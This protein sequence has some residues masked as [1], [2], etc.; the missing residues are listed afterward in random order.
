MENNNTYNEFDD[1]VGPWIGKT[2]KMLSLFLRDAFA[3]QG[4]DI[5]TQQFILLKVLHEAD[6]V[7][8]GDLAFITDRNKGSLTRLIS[9]LEKKNYVA[10][11]PSEDDKRINKIFLTRSGRDAYEKLKPIVRKSIDII[12]HGISPKEINTLISTLAK[13]QNNINQ[14]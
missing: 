13:I 11:I 6:G 14:K 3:E 9:T 12:Q 1:T 7:K 4:M 2:Q 8:Q 5:T 10:R